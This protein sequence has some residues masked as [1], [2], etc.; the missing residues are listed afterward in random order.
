MSTR[1]VIEATQFQ[2]TNEKRPYSVTVTPWGTAPSTCSFELWEKVGGTW[3]NRT[4]A[5]LTTGAVTVL[6]DVITS[7]LVSSLDAKNYLGMFRFTFG[8][9]EESC[10]FDIVGEK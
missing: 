1:H 10:I 4:A 6:G 9:T 3:T 5:F 2:G 7:G 8:T